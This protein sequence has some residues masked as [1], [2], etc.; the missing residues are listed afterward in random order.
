MIVNSIGN[1]TYTPK[2]GSSFRVGIFVKSE[3]GLGYTFIS[4][5]SDS[6]LY[7]KLNS[8]IVASLNS[9]FIDSLRTTF[10]IQRKNK[11]TKTLAQEYKKLID[12]L[13]E[14]DKDYRNFNLTRSLYRRNKLGYIV[15]GS[16]V[17]VVEN[18]KGVGQIG[19][20]KA[21]SLWVNG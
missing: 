19:L 5:Y 17:S 12:K 14:V 4:P 10:G 6:K 9:E 2:F 21:D 11:N 18:I 8:K 13:K 15:T 20:A 7:K 1:N 3:D 16:D